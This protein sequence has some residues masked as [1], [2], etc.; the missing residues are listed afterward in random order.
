MCRSYIGD[1]EFLDQFVQHGQ[2]RLVHAAHHLGC[3]LF[4]AVAHEVVDKALHGGLSG[5]RGHGA[6]LDA[7]HLLVD[8][9]NEVLRLERAVLL[10]RLISPIAGLRN[11]EYL[12]KRAVVRYTDVVACERVAHR[13]I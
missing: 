4:G 5:R 1:A 8:V 10:R 11:D 7:V 6:V 9:G 2:S 3:T 13:G 12:L